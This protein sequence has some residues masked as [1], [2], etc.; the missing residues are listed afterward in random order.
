MNRR[1]TKQKEMEDSS[2]VIVGIRNCRQYRLPTIDGRRLSADK[3]P[4][5]LQTR[6]SI[7]YI[8]LLM[9]FCVFF[10]NGCGTQ[11]PLH[12]Q[13]APLPS[14]PVCRL[15]VLPFLNDSDFLLGDVI[16]TKVFAAQLQEVSNYMVIPEGD[17]L[18][19]YQ[20]L[21]ILPGATPSLEQLQIIA[22][23]IN[24]QLLITGIIL[25]MRE[26]PG[27]NHGVNPLIV[28]EI[29]IRDVRSGEILWK[30]FHRRRGSDYKK[31]MH[32]GT[33]HTVTGLSRKM[34]EE[35]INLWLQKGL[36]QCNV[37]P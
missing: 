35:I 28:E 1:R 34:A 8:S 20:Q 33:I 37:L 22:D 11:L 19:T 10:L 6:C 32:F 16:G 25:E 26:D 23:R 18:K 12:R 9:L 31:T 14:D 13:M 4:D 36:T 7:F 15:A 27:E 21:Q 24:A 5:D 29:Q 3:T 2:F 30:T 17:I